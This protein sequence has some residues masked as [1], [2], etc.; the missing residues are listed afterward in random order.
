[1]G[2]AE[3]IDGIKR[4]GLGAYL[5][6]IRRG[7]RHGDPFVVRLSDGGTLHVRHAL[8]PEGDPGLWLVERIPEHGRAAVVAS[9]SGTV[10]SGE[11]LK[12]FS[13]RCSDEAWVAAADLGDPSTVVREALEAYLEA[14][15]PTYGTVK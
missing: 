6:S 8:P 13:F 5:P 7:L 9:E 10:S 3:L 1:M 2:R 15:H 11:H 14:H 4:A 12:R